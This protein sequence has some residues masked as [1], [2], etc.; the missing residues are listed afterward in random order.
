MSWQLA[1]L[2]AGL[3]LS[4]LLGVWLWARLVEAGDRAFIN[5]VYKPEGA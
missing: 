2:L 5:D 1:L 4:G 3:A